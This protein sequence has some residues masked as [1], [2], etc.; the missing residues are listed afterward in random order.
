MLRPAAGRVLRRRDARL[1]SPTGGYLLTAC[2]ASGRA[3]ARGLANWLRQ[4]AG[5]IG[6]RQ[7][8]GDMERKCRVPSAGAF[9]MS[10]TIRRATPADADACVPLIYSSGPAAFER[11]FASGQLTAQDFCARPSAPVSASSAAGNTG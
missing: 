11:V 10:L 6:E 4:Q 1:G 3:A 9:P 2:F 5:L 7:E 8:N